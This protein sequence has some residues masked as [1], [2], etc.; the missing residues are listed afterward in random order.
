M[1]TANTPRRLVASFGLCGLG[2]LP[3]LAQAHGAKAG[4]I[5]VNHPYAPPTPPGAT[6]GAVYFRGLRNRGGAPD[7]LIAAETPAAERVELHE[8][9]LEGDVMRMRAQPA[10]ELPAGAEVPAR[11][12]QRWHLMLLGLKAPLKLGDRFPLRLQ[13]ERG[14]R[15]EVTVW[16]QTPRGSEA[17]EK[18]EHRH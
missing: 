13:F 10:I 11:H 18:D 2:L 9:W 4:D 3:Q 8:M 15:V 17:A 12:G 7:R 5:A 6:T 1:A 16:V 14:G